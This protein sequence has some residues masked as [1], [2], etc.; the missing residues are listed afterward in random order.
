[1]QFLGTIRAKR[2]K[3]KL[4]YE[5]LLALLLLVEAKKEE[6]LLP[7]YEEPVV[8]R[9]LRSSRVASVP[10]KGFCLPGMG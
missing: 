9:L 4:R 3:I 5:Y 8:D 10:A 2:I 7:R 6:L 1:M